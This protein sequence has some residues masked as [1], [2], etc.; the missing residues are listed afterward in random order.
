MLEYFKV[1]LEKVS[2]N[3]ALFEKELRK[4]INY[5]SQQELP[6][7]W[8]WCNLQFGYKYAKIIDTCFMKLIRVPYLA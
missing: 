4:A 3:K 8:G 7:L 2:F 1:V 6:I 5:L